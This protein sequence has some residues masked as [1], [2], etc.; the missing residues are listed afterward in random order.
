MKKYYS[1]ILLEHGLLF[2]SVL[3]FRSI[4]TLLDQTQ[5]ANSSFGLWLML[6]IGILFATLTLRSIHMHKYP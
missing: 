4:W 3:I 2:A 1:L 5:W 6:V